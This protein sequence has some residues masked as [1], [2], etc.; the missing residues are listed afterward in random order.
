MT[1]PSSSPASSWR[2]WPAFAMVG[3]SRPRAPGTCCWRI[4]SM[5]P[6]IGSE[7][8]KAVR[9]GRS[10]SPSAAHASAVG[11][12]GRVVGPGRHQGGHRPDAD[13]A[14][15]GRERRVVRRP[16]VVG[17][18]AHAAGG[19]Q[20]ADVEHLGLLDRVAEH[21][22]DLRHVEV[23]GREAGVG[24]HDAREPVGVLGHQPQPEQPAPVLTEQR[25]LVQVEVVEGQLAHP[26]DVP[27]EGVVR[28]RER[29]VRPPEP[30]HVGRHAPDAGVG[31]DRDHVPVEE[32]PR[33]LAVQQQRDRSVGGTGVDVRHPQR[34]AVAVRAPRR[35]TAAT[36]SPAGRRSAR[37]GVR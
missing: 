23:A 37:P 4:A 8:L 32:R 9:N 10:H 21:P 12:G 19:D 3:W 36:G 14:L 24:G 17:H 28:Q 6:V 1:L 11:G 18:P 22:P 30:D 34:A 29:L 33:R 26:L 5:P 27:G 15:L 31:E 20:P 25:H 2:K 16:D 7:S 35:T 13:L